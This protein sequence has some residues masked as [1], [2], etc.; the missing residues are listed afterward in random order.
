MEISPSNNVTDGIG[1]SQCD[2]NHTNN[3]SEVLDDVIG[4]PL[5]PTAN[6]SFSTPHEPSRRKSLIKC[7]ESLQTSEEAEDEDCYDSDGN[8]PPCIKDT[9][10]NHFEAS[11]DTILSREISTI[12]ST[13]KFVFISDE[14]IDGLKVDEL[15]QELVKRSLSKSGLKAELRERLKKAMADRIAIADAEKSSAGPEGFD[16]GS[17]WVLLE[18]DMAAVEPT[19]VDPS[20]LDPSSFKYGDG[21]TITSSNKVLKMDYSSKFVRDEFI[22]E[23]LQPKIPLLSTTK[24]EENKSKK[25]KNAKAFN[26]RLITYTKKPTNGK[27]L[28]NIKFT[29]KNRLDEN[30]HPAEWL[31]ALIPDTP[32]K[33]SNQSFSKKQWC[34]YTNMKAELDCAGEKNQDG[35][36]YKFE[37]F[38]PQEIEQHLSLYIFQGLNPSPQLIMKTRSQSLEPLQG[39]DLIAE[40]LG[41]NFDRRHRQFRRYFACQHPY[42]PVPPTSSHPNWKVDPFM[43]HLN[44]VFIQAAVLPERLSVDEQT[45]Q[46]HG[47]SKLKSRIKYKKTGDGFQCD[48]ICSNGYTATFFFRHQPA[49]K[50][51]VD[52]GF[53]PL[54]SRILFMFE[55]LKNKNHSVYMDNLYMSATFARNSI[56]LQNKVKI[57]GVTRTDNRGIPSCVMQ[58]LIQNSKLADEQRNTVKVAVLKG[59]SSIKDLVAISFYDSK[60]VYFLSS[61]IPEVKWST[62]HKKV[63]SKVL[64]KKISLKFLRPNFVDDYNQDM[65]SVDRADQLRTNYNVGKGL[66]QRKWWWSIFLWGIDVAIVNA[67][68]LYKAWHEMHG[69]KPMT[70]YYFREKIAFAWL[71]E[72]RFWPGRYSRRPKIN[73]KSDCKKRKM[74][75]STLASSARVTRSVAS[76]TVTSGTSNKMCRT[77]NQGSLSNGSFDKRLVLSDEYT[78]LPAPAVSK[79][80]E[81]QLHKWADKRTRKQIA[82]CSD[83][84]VCLCIHCYKAFHTVLDLRRVKNDLENDRDIC[85]I[86]SKAEE[87]PLSAMTSNF[88]SV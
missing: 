38:T 17:K 57:H 11:I 9:D 74:H 8:E 12:P 75:V 85:I 31:R 19:C 55:Q 62:V 53:S 42:K 48:S 41:S 66:R 51:F 59:D 32:P 27:L 82:Y 5:T 30:S 2:T 70:H 10:F 76:S 25:R 4:S 60:P 1:E 64:D 36:G 72:E 28:P 80:S 16:Q 71:D 87:S 83:C 45:I 67:Y 21:K 34:Q 58:T 52:K 56:R 20:L 43:L 63:Y 15:R 14:D 78:H 18:P 47:A 37:N 50:K 84:N 49:P 23:A 22:G 29:R 81:C 68:L 73:I 39:N 86:A 61:V 46:F 65:N 13:S 44:N 40:K 69:L 77:L 54:H 24:S 88:S 3:P 33:G 35:L 7:F 79:Y 26:S 6:L